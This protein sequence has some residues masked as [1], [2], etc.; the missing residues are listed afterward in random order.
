MA[1]INNF[2]DSYADDFKLLTT[3]E[4]DFEDDDINIK[5][6]LVLFI[7]N[8]LCCCCIFHLIFILIQKLWELCL[9]YHENR[10]E[11][12]KIDKEEE[13]K[14]RKRQEEIMKKK[15]FDGEKTQE[16]KRM[17]DAGKTIK[18]ITT[19]LND[20]QHPTTTNTYQI[21]EDQYA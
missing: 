19:S 2:Y 1:Y 21:L 13:E 8:C 7:K 18:N 10:K 3:N 14:L 4:S 5:K 9:E 11:Q 20:L 12:K 6:L 16:S 15:W 17:E